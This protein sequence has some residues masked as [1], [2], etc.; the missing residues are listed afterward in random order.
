MLKT[1]I[2]R[3]PSKRAEEIFKSNSDVEFHFFP[4]YK[5]ESLPVD[6]NFIK[7]IHQGYF[8]WIIITSYKSWIFLIRQLDNNNMSISNHTKIAAFGPETAQRI[9]RLGRKVDF[10]KNVKNSKHFSKLLVESLEG[11]VKIAYLASLAAGEQVA[12]T[13]S[14]ANM[15]IIRQNIYK[16]KSI[17]DDNRI[18]KMIYSFNPDA[19]VFLSSASATLFTE[20]CSEE[21]LSR[22]K[23]MQLF[24]I[25]IETASTLKKLNYK[26][27]EVPDF[28]NLKSL[29][30]EIYNFGERC[31]KE[32]V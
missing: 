20:K 27:I 31:N 6:K 32:I 13:F 24:A 16:P 5:Y 28:P 11:D 7:N 14:Q 22:V 26:N 23:D 19:I 17:L 18:R 21:L 4:Y 3:E 25:G 30:K 2:T 29:S 1:V 15:Q 12:K 10:T 8:D 9:A